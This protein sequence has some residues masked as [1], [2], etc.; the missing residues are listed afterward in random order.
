MVSVEENYFENTCSVLSTS[1]RGK[2]EF[3]SY[4][5]ERKAEA[6]STSL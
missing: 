6:H 5:N 3:Y 1:R 4:A 2:N